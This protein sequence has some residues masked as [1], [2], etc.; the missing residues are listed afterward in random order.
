[1]SDADA[2]KVQIR[3]ITTDIPSICSLMKK[4]GEAHKFLAN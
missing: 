1:M 2:L 3:I 4:L